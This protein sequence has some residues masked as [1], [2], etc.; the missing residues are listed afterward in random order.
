VSRQHG[1]G[2]PFPPEFRA[3]AVDLYRRSG[4]SVETIAAE[5]GIGAETL[6]K[7][8]KRRLIEDGEEDGLK[9]SEREELR[10]LRRKVLRL[11]QERDLL[12]RAAA[13]FAKET[14]TR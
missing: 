6:R 8:H 11:E 2:R 4:K 5:L 1:R 13:F 14:E 12:K 10:E 3:E 9:Q 7:W